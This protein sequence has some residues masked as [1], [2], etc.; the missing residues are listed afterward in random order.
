MEEAMR[1][2][3]L[4]SWQLGSKEREEEIGVPLFPFK[5]MSL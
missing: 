5:V 3:P 4:I 2:K 1:T